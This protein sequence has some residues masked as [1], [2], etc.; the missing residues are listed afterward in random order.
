MTTHEGFSVCI[1]TAGW[2]I[3]SAQAQHFPTAGSHLER[4]AARFGAV[5]INSSFYR[6]HR[7]QTYAKWAASV[8]EHFRFAVKVPKSITHQHR[9]HNAE[10]PL[11]QFL[12]APTFQ[13]PV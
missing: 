13:W 12:S 5:E 2:G 10:E 9:L 4:Y 11:T 3:P 8:P 1:G 6:S 7:P